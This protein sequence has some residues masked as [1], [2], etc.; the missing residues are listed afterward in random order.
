MVAHFSYIIFSA[1][2]AYDVD[3]PICGYLSWVTSVKVEG[4]QAFSITKRIEIGE[5]H[6]VSV[7]SEF[8][9]NS[10]SKMITF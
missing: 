4:S 7:A 8:A 5:V 2:S 6:R 10:K 9:L 1:S 3:L